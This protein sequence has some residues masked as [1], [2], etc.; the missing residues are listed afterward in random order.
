ME[1][2]LLREA[3]NVDVGMLVALIREAFEQYR[4]QLE[5]PSGAHDETV[6]SM[7]SWLT[8]AH[9]VV[10]ILDQQPVGCVL[11]ELDGAVLTMSR[12]AVPPQHRGRGIGRELVAYVERRALEFGCT[13]V[14]LGVRLALAALIGWYGALGYREVARGTYEG[15]SQPMYAILEK[16]IGFEPRPG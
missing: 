9:A 3:T 15:F 14:Q 10:A 8:G 1:E 2:L 12:L 6:E 4:G 13:R 5:P 7:L 16:P 11:Y